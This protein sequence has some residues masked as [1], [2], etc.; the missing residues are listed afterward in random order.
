MYITVRKVDEYDQAMA[1][2]HVGACYQLNKGS[3]SPIDIGSRQQVRLY[4]ECGQLSCRFYLFEH[5]TVMYTLPATIQSQ[6]FM[7][8]ALSMVNN[9]VLCYIDSI[10]VAPC[11]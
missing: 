9:S 10:R 1:H 2:F 11:F 8:L 4:S 3:H 7:C 6:S 5:I